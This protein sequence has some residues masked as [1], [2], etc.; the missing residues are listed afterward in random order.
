MLEKTTTK[1][2]RKVEKNDIVRRG[3]WYIERKHRIDLLLKFFRQDVAN[4]S[5]PFFILPYVIQNCNP[6]WSVK[7]TLEPLKPTKTGGYVRLFTVVCGGE[8]GVS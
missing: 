1:N 5:I 8:S 6:V 7:K 3:R 2:D 4:F